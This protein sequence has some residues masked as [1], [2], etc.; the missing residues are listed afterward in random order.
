MAV[1][2]KR[3]CG[4]R[5]VGGLYLVGGGGGINCD[6]LPI[7]LE[8]C[9]CCG[10]GIK[11]TR[12]WTWV[13]IAALVGGDHGNLHPTDSGPNMYFV[14]CGCAPFCPLC[15][16]T[17]AMGRGGLLWIGAQFYPTIEHF[18]AEAKHLGV[19][20]RI[21]SLPRGFEIGKTWVLFAHARGIIKPQGD[22]VAKYVP[23][24]FRVWKPER[25]ERIYKESDRNGEAAQADEKRGI[26]PVFVPDSDR[27]H[28]GTCYDKDEEPGGAPIPVAQPHMDFGQ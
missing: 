27:D 12:G 7:A 28:Q 6:R 17:K 24:I 14:P 9:N 16:N 25:V 26:V 2:A 18:E 13:D 4:Y 3:G 11:Q 22:L 8:I 20:R 21:T 15:H 5:K 1:E 19:S 10:Q 23:A